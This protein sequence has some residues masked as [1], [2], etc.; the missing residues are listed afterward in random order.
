[1]ELA[2]ASLR[3]APR[4]VLVARELM[5]APAQPFKRMGAQ[6]VLR[7]PVSAG[8]VALEARDRVPATMVALEG[9]VAAVAA[10]EPAAEPEP[11]GLMAWA[12]R[13]AVQ[14]LPEILRV[15]EVVALTVERRAAPPTPPL[16]A[17]LGV[18]TSPELV[19][20][21]ESRKIRRASMERMAAA[22]QVVALRLQAR[23]D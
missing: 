3:Q 20:P 6:V 13:G 11:V 9:L 4:V 18:I 1:M 16:R 15:P 17:A 5:A 23:P 19:V 10:L 21:P 7:T 22:V 2:A 8:L 14:T 12:R